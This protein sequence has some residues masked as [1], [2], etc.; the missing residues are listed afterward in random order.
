M[1]SPT[2]W[3]WPFRCT[4]CGD[5]YPADSLPFRCPQCNSIF[6]FVEGLTFDPISMAK[7]SPSL[8]RYRKSLGLPPEAELI[9]LGEGDT[10]LV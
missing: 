6:D 8:V 3:Q 5:P 2:D 9:T 7:P 10:P 4:G 1:T